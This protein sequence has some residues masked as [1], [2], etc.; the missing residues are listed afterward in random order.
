MKTTFS[1]IFFTAI[2]IL[3]VALVLVG[4]FLRLLVKDYLTDNAIEILQNDAR[5]ISE[6]AEVYHSSSR[7][8]TI[9]F[10]FNLNVASQVSGADAVIC[11]KDGKVVFC[12]DSP[13]GCEHQGM[14]VNRDYML[15]VLE[16]NGSVNTGIIENL[17]DDVRYIVAAPVTNTATGQNMGMV[18]VSSPLAA[19]NLVLKKI[20]DI[21]FIISAYFPY[22]ILIYFILSICF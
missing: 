6:L 18:I 20:T 1:R 21:F 9:D 12:S 2:I 10:I 11:D 22:M 15:N 19:T 14:Q 4:V 8:S 13:M 17:Y 3:M 16:N 7:A 5:V